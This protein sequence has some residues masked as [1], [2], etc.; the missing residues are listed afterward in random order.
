MEPGFYK[1][2][3]ARIIPQVN[4]QIKLQKE[5]VIQPLKPDIS[6]VVFK[7]HP[8]GTDFLTGAENE[9]NTFKRILLLFSSNELQITTRNSGSEKFY[10]LV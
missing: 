4:I 9:K 6:P 7:G 1:L 3:K 5:L 8:E 2:G 10:L